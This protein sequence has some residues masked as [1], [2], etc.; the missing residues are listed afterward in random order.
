MKN[1][2]KVKISDRKRIA[3]KSDGTQIPVIDAKFDVLIQPNEQDIHDGIKGDPAQCMYCV[4]CRRQFASE[5]V[6]VARG[7]A[8]V[9]LKGKGG[10]SI[11]ERFILKDPARINLR[12]F[13]TGVADLTPEAVIFAA[14]KGR[15][16]LDGLNRNYRKWVEDGK[17]SRKTALLKGIRKS[18]NGLRASQTIKDIGLRDPQ[19]GMF[20]FKSRL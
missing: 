20:Q 16:T 5:L 10:K 19:T 6:W 8:Y 14:P 2:I 17:P 1:S 15:Q 4:A 13:D 11:L 7:V 18:K 12:K 3:L 9:E